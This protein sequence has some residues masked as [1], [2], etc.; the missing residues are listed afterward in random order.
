[1][2][3]LN[4]Q[5]VELSGSKLIEASAGTGKT[6]S[7]ALLVLRLILE[8]EVPIDKML[9]V[10]FTKAATAELELRI[11]KFVR[12]AYRY[13]S[14]GHSCD[15]E[16]TDLVDKAGKQI[17]LSKLKPALQ[18]LDNLSVMTI[19]SFCQKTIGEFTFETNQSFDFEIVTDDSLILKNAT[20]QFVR[21]TLN[22]LDYE[23]YKEITEDL[24]IEAMDKMLRNHLQGMRFLEDRKST[25]LN[26][27]HH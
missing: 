16:I 24:K 14:A 3:E 10:T 1:M 23:Q 17:S 26:S 22:M 19:H 11:R 18:S 15:R 6:Y 4:L 5:D 21:E 12:L 27:S 13:A 2:E 25:R 8:K 20:N 9:M 7:V